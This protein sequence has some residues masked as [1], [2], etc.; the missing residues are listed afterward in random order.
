MLS[1]TSSEIIQ[2]LKKYDMFLSSL[3]IIQEP[4]EKEKIYDE[5]DKLEEK[6]LLAV[7]SEYEQAYVFI[8]GREINTLEEEKKRLNDVIDLIEKQKDYY[9]QRKKR[10]EDIT[11]SLVEL[12]T[13]IGEDKLE[14]Y[15]KR[16]QIIEKYQ[17][18]MKQKQN[19]EEDIKSLDIRINDANMKI[20]T[21]TNVNNSLENKMKVL[22]HTTF[23]KLELYDLVKNKDTIEDEYNRLDYAKK[24]ASDNLKYAK[25]KGNEDMIVECD[26]LLSSITLDFEKAKEAK[27]TLRLIEIY[28]RVVDDYDELL[29]KRE[30]INDILKEITSSKLYSLVKDELNKQYNTIKISGQDLNTYRSLTEEKENKNKILQKILDENESK[31]FKDVL[32]D[33]LEIEKKYNEKLLMEQRKREYEEGQRRLIEEKKLQEERLRRQKLVEEERRKAQEATSK[34]LL[35]Q[36]KKSVLKEELPDFDLEKQEKEV[37]LVTPPSKIE[38]PDLKEENDE[39]LSLKEDNEDIFPNDNVENNE[40]VND[41]K[42]VNGIPIIENN[43]SISKQEEKIEKDDQDTIK[44]EDIIF[45]DFMSN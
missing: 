15:K 20:K 30:E 33:L 34:M 22:L 14:D 6:I 38:L 19:L 28:D 3:K 12:T 16:L 39:I 4:T 26:N 41:I 10:H 7:N 36:Q 1:Y 45:P 43:N 13:F 29:T 35:E 25:N 40:E 32:E 44:T 8:V 21:N 27:L 42:M 5:L 9:K 17:A 37:K 11:G 18:N 24:I 2:L 23:D 31:E